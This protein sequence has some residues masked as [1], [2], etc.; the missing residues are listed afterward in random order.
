[1]S[2]PTFSTESQWLA[3]LAAM[4][5]AIA[6]LKL[7]QRNGSS[8]PYGHDILVDEDETSDSSGKNDIWDVFSEPD[9]DEDDSDL[10]DG[11]DGAVIDDKT[12]S[13]ECSEWLREKCL[14][15]AARNGGSSTDEMQ[16]QISALL[17]SDM[18][19]KQSFVRF[20]R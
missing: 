3:Q 11:V 18:Q 19:G 1:M 9:E 15:L 17:A 16:G 2:P 12:R 20:Q 5:Q 14:D 8:L 13:K 10:V 7:D 6:E 4:R